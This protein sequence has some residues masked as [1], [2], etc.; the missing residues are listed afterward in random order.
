MKNF[1]EDMGINGHLTIIRQW[2]D[3]QEEILLDDSNIIVSGM[4]VGLSHLFTGS[5]SDSILDYQID[6]FQVGVSGPP[7]GGVTSS[8]YEL[9]GPLHATGTN[10]YGSGSNLFVSI[11]PQLTN[12]SLTSNRTFALI[13]NNKITRIGNS[14]VRYTLV[15]DEEACNDLTRDSEDASLNEVGMFMKNPTGNADDQSLLVCYRT[16]SNIRKTSDFSLIFRWT[17]NF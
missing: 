9:S 5:G 6:R 2:N 11:N 8:I 10:E 7:Q 3:G 14:S 17:L 16:F 12:D 4:G 13:P 1:T 15:L